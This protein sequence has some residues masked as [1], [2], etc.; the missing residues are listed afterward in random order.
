MSNVVLAQDII[1]A[2]DKLPLR[3]KRLFVMGL[4]H[5]TSAMSLLSS[6]TYDK[7]PDPNKEYSFT[8]AKYIV[9]QELKKTSGER[10]EEIADADPDH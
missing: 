4:E 9:M 7:L 3:M 1:H 6:L 5:K 10:I 2:L 8:E